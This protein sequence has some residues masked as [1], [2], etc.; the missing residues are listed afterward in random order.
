M[1][2]VTNMISGGW[3]SDATK[4][5][6]ICLGRPAQAQAPCRTA[7][8]TTGLAAAWRSSHYTDTSM[9]LQTG[10]SGTNSHLRPEADY[11]EFAT[12]ASV[13]HNPD[14]SQSVVGVVS[15]E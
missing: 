4:L 5:R 7:T 1:V 6:M 13:R 9:P 3:P 8:C 15:N 12:G 11:I 2:Q 14:A 10:C